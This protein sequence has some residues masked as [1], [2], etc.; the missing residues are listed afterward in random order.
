M[1]YQMEDLGKNLVKL[2]IEVETDE[3]KKA[4]KSAYNKSKK[5]FNIPGFRK[6]K[7]SYEVVAK[8]YGEEMFYADAADIMVPDAFEKA[9]KEAE[10][11]IASSP[12]VE[13]KKFEKG[14]NFVFE[15]TV[16][17]TPEVKLGTYKGV[18]IEKR[19]ADVTD[20][21]ITAELDKE[22]EANSR[23]VL[24]E[25]RAAEK[26]DTTV[27]DYEGF[28]DGVAFAG[29]KSE[30]Y[31]LELGSNTFIPGFEDQIVGKNSGDEF[32]VNVTFPEEY[33]SP[34]LK[35]KAAVFKVKV[36]E[37]K[38]KELPELDD[39]FASE[40]SEFD[41]LDEYKEDVKK[42]LIEKKEKDN[43]A[44]KAEEALAKAIENAEM[45][46]PE[47][48]IKDNVRQMV[49]DFEYR[50]SMQG[51]SADQYLQMMGMTRQQLEEQMTPNAEQRIKSSLLLKAV[52]EAEKIEASEDDVDEE[53]KRTAEIYGM[54]F[55][56]LKSQVT[57][58]ERSQIKDDLKLK[59]A[60]EFI[61]EN[62]VEK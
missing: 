43:E 36:K 54:E 56:K 18:E 48:M 62:A 3:V 23:L 49:R 46:I 52:A 53:L 39:E 32:D 26:G 42:K 22:R 25:D 33:H 20:E 51:I 29:G 60:S 1:S 12:E 17:V 4:L 16:A 11:D 21:E 59:K 24:V 30:D 31:P 45:D 37:I 28:V 35:G 19:S 34:D 27:I 13:V 6:G 15:A 50:V 7:A 5:Q 2:T 47:L 58:E 8:M 40:V 44:Q 14:E 55:D 38:H 10:I 61:T 41:T 57:D 9:V